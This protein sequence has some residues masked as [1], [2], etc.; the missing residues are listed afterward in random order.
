VGVRSGVPHQPTRKYPHFCHADRQRNSQNSAKRQRFQTVR[1]W[2]FISAYPVHR[3]PRLA[4]FFVGRAIRAPALARH[5]R[6]RGVT[7]TRLPDSRPLPHPCGKWRSNF[8]ALTTSPP[9]NQ[10]CR[11]QA[12]WV[13]QHRAALRGVPHCFVIRFALHAIIAP[14]ATSPWQSQFIT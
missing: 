6:V 13:R 7:L 2:R 10:A 4:V 12:L 14:V 11:R 9:G 5:R 1:F 8:T 3:P